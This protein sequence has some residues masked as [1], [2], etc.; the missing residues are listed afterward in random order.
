MLLAM[1]GGSWSSHFLPKVPRVLRGTFGG[2]DHE[3]SVANLVRAVGERE[4]AVKSLQALTVGEWGD[5]RREVTS[6]IFRKTPGQLSYCR[7]GVFCCQKIK[8]SVT[9]NG[10]RYPR[11]GGRRDAVR[12]GK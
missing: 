1:L 5:I 4:N 9:P 11:W 8:Q 3:V 2:L 7:S 6:A 10:L 12:L